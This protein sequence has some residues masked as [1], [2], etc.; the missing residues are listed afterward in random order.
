ML[1]PSLPWLA[2][3]YRNLKRE[4]FFRPH[5]AMDSAQHRYVET[6]SRDLELRPSTPAS[7]QGR[8]VK[9]ATHL[10]VHSSAVKHR[11]SRPRSA[12]ATSSHRNERVGCYNY[13]PEDTARLSALMNRRPKSATAVLLKHRPSSA[14]NKSVTQ[15]ERLH[16]QEQVIRRYTE[17]TGEEVQHSCPFCPVECRPASSSSHRPTSSTGLLAAHLPSHH[18]RKSNWTRPKTAPTTR[19]EL[20][21]LPRHSNIRRGHIAYYTNFVSQ[22]PLHAR[23]CTSSPPIPR[24]RRAFQEDPAPPPV[25]KFEDAGAGEEEEEEEVEVDDN[26]VEDELDFGEDDEAEPVEP[27]PIPTPSPVVK[28]TPTPEPPAETR[29]AWSPTS[30][31]PTPT[32]IESR[33]NSV[34]EP[35]PPVIPQKPPSP[36]PPKSPVPPKSPSP[37]P[38]PPA[39][40]PPRKSPLPPPKPETPPPPQPPS[41]PK[42]CAHKPKVPIPPLPKVKKEVRIQEPPK[43]EPKVPEKKEKKPIE[44][45][46]KPPEEP[47]KPTPPK[48]AL[49]KTPSQPEVV[50]APPLKPEPVPEPEPQPQEEPKDEPEPQPP[51][52]EEKEEPPVEEKK[53]LGPPPK[54]KVDVF[55]MDPQVGEISFSLRCFAFSILIPQQDKK[56]S[57]QRKISVLLMFQPIMCITYMQTCMQAKMLMF[58]FCFISSLPTALLCSLDVHI[59]FLFLTLMTTQTMR[60]LLDI[61]MKLKRRGRGSLSDDEDDEPPPASL[62]S[63]VEPTNRMLKQSEWLRG[64]IALSRRAARF[65]L[66]MDVGELAEMT[67]VEYLSKY[68]IISHRRRALYKKAFSRADKDNDG[69]INRKELETAVLDALVDTIQAD[70]VNLVLKFLGAEQH[71]VY[72]SR[73][74][75]AFCALLERLYYKE[76]AKEDSSERKEEK[77]KEI[78]EEADFTGLDWKLQGQ[79]VNPDLKELLYKL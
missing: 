27:T 64:R 17:D 19:R 22:L 71:S 2:S 45:E 77:E 79:Y 35:V 32:P 39:S 63:L 18:D 33:R 46:K 54:V 68:C 13:S 42:E 61:Q 14:Q 50:V 37:R 41:H 66:P 30:I 73:F 44:T 15:V 26:P 62:A 10:R 53:K 65:E 38:S 67:P 70:K 11:F 49:K 57:L 21:Q 5:S 1:D 3:G 29:E 9:S 24:R 56:F 36:L 6:G 48:P 76:F 25:V 12:R 59:L 69:K 72:T 7:R 74:F 78:L 8:R 43:E 31:A 4:D 23:E 20:S 16:H 55:S 28:M 52:E 58:V 40:P 47:L 34:E 60:E 75:A 51:K